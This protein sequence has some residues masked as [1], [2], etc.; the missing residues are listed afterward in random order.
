MIDLT[1]VKHHVAIEEIVEV[2]CNKTQNTDK[3]FFRMEVAYFLGKVAANMRATISTKDRGKIPVNIYAILLAMSGFGKGHS[4]GIIENEILKDFKQRFTTETFFQIAQ[5]N[6]VT[7]ATERALSSGKTVD[8][9]LETLEKEFNQAGEFPYTFDSGTTP[10]IKQLRHKLLLAGCGAINLQIDEIGSNIL[11]STEILNA[12]LELY[13][14]GMIKQKLTKN[15]QENIRA[16]EVDGKTPTNMLLF[17]TPAK[18]LDG[19]KVEDHFYSMLE[20]GYGRRCLFSLANTESRSYLSLSPEEIYRNLTNPSNHQL[21]NKWSDIFYELACPTLFNWTMDVSDDVGIKLTEYRVNCEIAAHKL[22]EHEEI[23]KAEMSHR[24][25]KALKLAGAYAFIDKSLE[26]TM[27]HLLSAILLVEESGESFSKI[28]DRDKAYMKVAKYIASTKD[29][30][31]HADLYE[32]LPF[33]K[34][35]TSA[36]NELMT[37]ARAWGYKENIL[38]KNRFIDGIEFFRGET[39]KESDA[40]ELIL[41]CSTDYDRGYEPGVLPIVSEVDDEGNP[42]NYD[43]VT[44][45]QHNEILHWCNHRFKNKHRTEDNAIT[46]FNMIVVDIDEGVRLETAKELLEDYKFITHTTKRHTEENNRF[47]LIIPIK[48]E[49]HLDAKEYKLFMSNFLEWLPFKVDEATQQ[50]SRKWET[51]PNCSIHVN[52]GE[53]LDV[54]QFIPDTTKND[55]F[56]RDMKEIESLDNLERWFAI[57]MVEGNRNNLMLRFAMANVDSG[58]DFNTVS[59]RVLNFNRKLNNSLPEEELHQTVL[60][61]VAKRYQQAN[62]K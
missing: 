53:L 42:I 7:L 49:L 62:M 21:I 11:D 52:D 40:S 39:L 38:I 58:L 56:K 9:E 33:Y 5:Q 10:A 44:F 1:G 4:I 8:E 22:P 20:T 14:Q 19:S 26:I 47:R 17:G 55:Q 46:G 12:Y 57:R 18:L 6:L 50:R 32:A 25:Y 28:L 41:S 27:D 24:Y 51:C 54:T 59:E 36:R 60:Q 29:E 34:A 2:L 15:T 45:L 35:G 16:R 43:L 30:V 61:S 13:D 3:S 23:R 37:M 48:Y 31:T